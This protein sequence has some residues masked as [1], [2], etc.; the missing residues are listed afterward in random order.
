MHR[1]NDLWLQG[2]AVQ[3]SALQL[4]TYNAAFLGTA[5]LQT[6]RMGLTAPRTFW[7]ALARAQADPKA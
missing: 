1:F 7:T 4:A 5:T 6:M 3:A 2:Q